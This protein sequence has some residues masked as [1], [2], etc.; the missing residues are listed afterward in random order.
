MVS[1]HNRY[2][3]LELVNEAEKDKENES[4]KEEDEGQPRPGHSRPGNKTNSIKNP[5]SVIVVGDSILRCAEGPIYRPDPLHR[6]ICCLPGAWVKDFT[7]KLPA[8][9][10]PHV[11]GVLAKLLSIIYQQSWLTGEVSTD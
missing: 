6:E 9:V 8:L 4:N 1:L 7:A 10:R 2:G 5:R 11:A 3:A